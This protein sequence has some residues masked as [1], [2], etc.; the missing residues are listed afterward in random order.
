MNK[1]ILAQL[2]IW[3]A[4]PAAWQ[5]SA[6]DA[7]PAE[8][9]VAPPAKS[10][11]RFNLSLRMG[12]NITADFKNAGS[13]APQGHLVPIPG[14]GSVQEPANPNGDSIGNRTYQDGYVWVDSSGNALGYS[15]YWGYDNSSQY[16]PATGTIL[17]HSSS[18]PG[19]SSNG[20]DGD[21]QMGF[22]FSYNHN[23]SKSD[24]WNWGLEAAFNFMNLTI[25][26][27]QPLTGSGTLISDAFQLPPEFGGEGFVIPPPAPYSHGPFLTPGTG[28]PVI[29]ATPTRL[30]LSNFPTSITG[31]RHFD[32]NV[33]GWRLG[34]YA[35][36][37]LG[38][39]VSIAISGG[40]ALAAITSDFS[41]KETVTFD[42]NIGT[43]VTTQTSA[44][45]GSDAGVQI[46]GFVSGTCTVALSEKWNLFAGAQFQDV[47]TYT[48]NL[49][50]RQARVDLSASVFVNVGLAFS[51]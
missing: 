37:P 22:E 5:S 14:Q 18:S 10:P 7:A 46:G 29:G 34:P 24:K 32:A 50:S 12:F 9:L 8:Q 31:S 19:T 21:P 45:S 3:L 33:F 40:L 1:R 51:F 4:M 26:D 38:K 36:L 28:N 11:D 41:Y 49:G 23:F 25:N 35:E 42:Q 43:G 6:Q 2:L 47:G 20:R 39:R 17:M 27:N 48:Q 15:R 30:P 16:N 44:G 13:I